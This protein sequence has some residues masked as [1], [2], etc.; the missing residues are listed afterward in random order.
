M[1][2]KKPFH[3]HFHSAYKRTLF[4]LI[5]I[6]SV[7]TIGTIGMHLLEKMPYLDAFYFMSM[8][9][10]AQGPT[11][12]PATAAGKI[13]ASI[14]AFISV[15]TVITALGFLFGP[16]LGQLGHVGVMHLEKDLKPKK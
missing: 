7:M 14:I 9:A 11:L 12:M 1:P 5:L 3:H 6:F 10:T 2:V 16:L 13:F 8:L 4:S 15:G